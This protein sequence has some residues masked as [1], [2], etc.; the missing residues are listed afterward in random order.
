MQPSARCGGEE[1]LFSTAAAD[2]GTVLLTDVALCW[3][4]EEDGDN[5]CPQC[6]AFVGSVATILQT[7]AGDEMPLKLPRLGSTEV[8]SLEK[9]VCPRAPPAHAPRLDLGQAPAGGEQPISQLQVGA[10]LIARD[11]WEQVQMGAQMVATMARVHSE[12]ARTGDP[13]GAADD[14]SELA[15]LDALAAPSWEAVCRA[16]GDDDPL[17]EALPRDTLPVLRDALQRQLQADMP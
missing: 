16:D 10:S 4:P 9:H 6:G 7:L 11:G 13:D 14:P 3:L 12:A 8:P 1:G 5:T 15:L 2:E 17:A